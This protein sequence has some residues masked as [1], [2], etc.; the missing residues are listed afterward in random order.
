MDALILM[1]RVPIPGTTKTR[2][3]NFITHEKCAQ[4]HKHFLM[5][6][7]N[8]FNKINNKIDIFLTYT[9]S[10][11]FYLIE[12]YMPKYISHFPQE[13]ETLGDRMKNAMLHVLSKGYEKVVLIGSD[14]PD[15]SKEDI[16]KAFDKLDNSN[17]CI[18]P[19]FDGGYYLIGMKEIYDKI[20]FIQIK[21]ILQKDYTIN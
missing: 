2:L 20:F 7:F 5:D 10:D 14:I 21:N 4:L 9:P 15:L 12:D 19:T 16:L 1:T 18:G 3:S 8:T 11:K 13:G 17:I 6:L